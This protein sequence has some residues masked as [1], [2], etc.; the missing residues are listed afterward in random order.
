MIYVTDTHPFVFYALGLTRKL[1]RNALRVF[2]RAE[3]HQDMVRIPS[4]C[5]FELA[6][7][8]ESGKIRAS[9]SFP[10]WKQKMETSGAFVVEPLT[11]EDIAEAYA[12]TV[13]VDPFDR[14]IAGTANRLRCPLITRDSR[15]AESR[16]VATTW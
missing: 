11:W 13:L 12:L 14:L 1:G 4:V 5:F 3:N 7:L 16:L 10:D 8:V 6:L 9:L 2:T 15:I